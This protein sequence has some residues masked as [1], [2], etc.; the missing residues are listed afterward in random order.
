[1]RRSAI[2]LAACVIVAGGHAADTKD[3]VQARA[4][5]T[6]AEGKRLIGRAVAQMPMVR[7]ALSEGMLIITRGTTNT[8]VAEEILGKKLKPGAFVTGRTLP[9]KGGKRLPRVT[10]RLEIVLVKGKVRDDLAFA[11]A[12]AK[13]KPGDVVIKGAN[14]LDYQNRTAG[15]LIGAPNSGTTGTF[16]PYVVAKKAHL[17]VPVGLE[18]QV[19]GN[20]IE[21]SSKLREPMEGLNRVPSMFPLIGA[22][23]VTE[24]EALNILAGVEAFQAAAGGIGGAEGAS[25][26]VFRGTRDQ[27]Q[28]AL[29]VVDQIQGEPPFVR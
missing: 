2:A 15:V 6:V 3:L 24:L 13:L 29:R 26:V 19:T 28:K 5:L 10:R 11:D 1:M 21:T 25:W 16:M 27:V 12:V 9:E 14:A 18:K 23:I 4:V 8:Y 22:R 20:L 17:V 7:R